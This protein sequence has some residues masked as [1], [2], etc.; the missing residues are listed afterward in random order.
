MTYA[1]C[2]DNGLPRLYRRTCLAAEGLICK[3]DREQN[4]LFIDP[5]QFDLLTKTEQHIVLRTQR[6]YIAPGDVLDTPSFR[7]ST[8]P[9]GM[10]EAAE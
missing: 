3:L 10:S 5:V 8:H 1:M 2:P 9:R 7:Y 6:P 4:I